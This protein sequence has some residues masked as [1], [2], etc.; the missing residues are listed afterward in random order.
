MHS[1]AIDPV[2]A[3]VTLMSG[4]ALV[5]VFFTLLALA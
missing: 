1:Y 4:W 2:P 3:S 5:A